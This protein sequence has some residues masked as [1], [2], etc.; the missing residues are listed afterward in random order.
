MTCGEEGEPCT[1]SLARTVAGEE[2]EAEGAGGGGALAVEA[3]TASVALS[4]LPLVDL[5]IRVGSAGFGVTSPDPPA[6]LPGTE[7]GLSV[8]SFCPPLALTVLSPSP[9]RLNPCISL[10]GEELIVESMFALFCVF[11]TRESI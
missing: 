2:E 4:V 9:E 11:E 7:L 1:I 3:S 5:G 6:G 8:S 10:V